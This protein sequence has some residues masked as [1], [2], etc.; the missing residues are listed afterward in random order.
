MNHNDP[1]L[2][3]YYSERASEYEQIY[4]R[5]V[6]QRQ[7][8]L[9]AD[10]ERLQHLVKDCTL[11]DLACGTGYWL[12][13]MSETARHITAVDISREMIEQAKLKTFGCPVD[14]VRSDINDLPFGPDLFDCVTL[15]FWFSHQPRQHYGE[16]YKALL[17][18]IKKNG[19]IWMIDNNPPA[20]G[21]SHNSCGTD[22]HGNNLITRKLDSG[23]EYT[24]IKNYFNRDQLVAL[25]SPEFQI[26]RLTYGV[27]YWSLVLKS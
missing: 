4:Y 14:F 21:V 8:E 1:E 3:K 27:C 12:E 13:K 7:M 24:I 9:A 6:P 18:F 25:L 16:L 19:S 10:T 26:E 22:K 15:G 2:L 5:D 11:L 23:E 17:S 20:E